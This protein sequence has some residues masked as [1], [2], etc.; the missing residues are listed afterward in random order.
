MGIITII[1]NNM[2]NMN[3]ARSYIEIE[4]DADIDM[5]IEG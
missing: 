2:P 4:K 1:L 3:Y 5:D